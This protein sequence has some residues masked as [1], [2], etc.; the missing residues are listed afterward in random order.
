[1][2]KIFNKHVNH[3]P[4]VD[5]FRELL[6]Q[7]LYHSHGQAMQTAS[8]HDAYMALS[9]TVRD[10]LI[11]RWRRTT[12]TRY[13]T[14]PKFVYYLSAEYLLGKQLPQNLLYTETT[15]IAR[16]ALAHYNVDLEDLIAM[17]IEPGL[18]N[19]GLGRLAAC[20][21]DSLAT[22]DFPATGYGIRYEFGIFQ[23][24]FENGWQVEHPDEWALRGNPWEFVQSDDLVKVG[25]GGHTE[26]YRDAGGNARIRWLPAETVLGEPCTQ[27]VPGYRTPTVNILRLWQARASEEFDFRLFNEGDYEQR[28][29]TEGAVRKHQQSALS[30]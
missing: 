24:T 3:Q 1:M 26:P 21:I 13:E 8:M 12:D 29:A 19:G 25:F 6:L 22:L 9:Y 17:D 27:L 20:F 5:E 28:G 30:E 10:Y 16:Q 15:E 2:G 4:T 18:G 7:N 23:Q 14:N 11:D